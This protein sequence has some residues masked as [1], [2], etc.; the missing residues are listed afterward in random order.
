MLTISDLQVV[1]PNGH[2]ALKTISFSAQKGEIIAIIGRSGAGKSTLIRCINGLQKPVRGSIILD[3]QEI[4]TLDESQLRRVR[5]QIG[6][7]WQ[8]YNLVDRLSTMT[9]VLTGR[10]GYN[11]GI[12]PL[13]GIFGRDDRAIAVR[14]LERVNL[15]HRAQQRADSLSGGEK[16]RVSIARAMTQQPKLILADEPVA[17]LDPAL[18]WQIVNDISRLAREDNVLTIINIHQTELAKEFADR[19][20][21]IANGLVVFDGKPT[22]LDDSAMDR[23]YMFDDKYNA[24]HEP[25]PSAV[26]LTT[27]ISEIRWRGPE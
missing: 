17:S 1:Y 12:A 4:T 27:W 23:V 3:N 26:A 22:E 2:E 7:I 8:E 21:G 9:N 13:L 18:S 11:D 10:L 5:R 19:V 16:Q 25:Q 24:A 15:L 14:N 6:F 20:I